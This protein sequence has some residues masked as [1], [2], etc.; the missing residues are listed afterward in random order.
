MGKQSP[1]FFK[2]N[3]GGKWMKAFISMRKEEII[4]ICKNVHVWITAYENKIKE[5]KIQELMNRWYWKLTREQAEKKELYLEH[6]NFMYRI[7]KYKYT[8]AW[9]IS[10]TL[11]DMC[12]NS[13]DGMV[14]IGDDWS[15]FLT[16][17]RGKK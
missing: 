13:V 14:N 15:D 6:D 4:P 16:T 12:S 9:N 10:T 5:E 11:L 2:V 7:K 17:W 1:S 8:T 3:I